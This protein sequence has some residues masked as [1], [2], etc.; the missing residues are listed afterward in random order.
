MIIILS[1]FYRSWKLGLDYLGSYHDHFPSGQ[2]QASSFTLV[3]AREMEIITTA[4]ISEDCGKNLVAFP[5]VLEQC[6]VT[7]KALHPGT[8]IVFIV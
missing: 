3:L 5:K 4:L 6:F 7:E 1:Q 2:L 8:P